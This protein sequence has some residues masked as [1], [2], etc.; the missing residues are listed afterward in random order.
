MAT[1]GDSSTSDTRL[2]KAMKA[3]SVSATSQTK[4]RC[5]TAPTSTN[6][7]QSNRYGFSDFVPTRYSQHFSP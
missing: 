7:V 4:S 5:V 6:A 2:G 1:T 3:F